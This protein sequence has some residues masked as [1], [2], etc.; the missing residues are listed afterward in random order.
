MHSLFLV[1]YCLVSKFSALMFVLVLLILSLFL[2]MVAAP[3]VVVVAVFLC[4]TLLRHFYSAKS[5]KQSIVCNS[6]KTMPL[7]FVLKTSENIHLSRRAH[8]LSCYLPSLYA[9]AAAVCVYVCMCRTKT[10]I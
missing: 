6:I 5:A 10:C 2:A 4:H 8:F 9:V 7:Y 3:L 1:R